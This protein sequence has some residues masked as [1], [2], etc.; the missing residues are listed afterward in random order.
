MEKKHFELSAVEQLNITYQG[1]KLL[2]KRLRKALYILTLHSKLHA[3]KEGVFEL[4]D[5]DFTCMNKEDIKEEVRPSALSDIV[6]RMRELEQLGKLEIIEHSGEEF[7]KPSKYRLLNNAV[8]AKR[9]RY[10]KA[11]RVCS[12]SDVSVSRIVGIISANTKGRSA[13]GK[14]TCSCSSR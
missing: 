3:D 5:Y 2:E 8:G 9:I 10:I 4:S 11:L 7:K 14:K 6:V 12:A 13:Y 1:K